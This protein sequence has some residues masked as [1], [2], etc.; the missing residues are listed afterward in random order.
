MTVR[1]PC[2]EHPISLKLDSL[3]MRYN[4][5]RKTKNFLEKKILRE[6]TSNNILDFPPKKSF[7]QKDIFFRKS[8]FLKNM[9][10]DFRFFIRFFLVGFRVIVRTREVFQMVSGVSIDTYLIT[11]KNPNKK[12]YFIMEKKYFLKNIFFEKSK[13]FGENLKMLILNE[14]SK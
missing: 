11:E 6:K 1:S 9:I 12:Q 10:F 13:I 14:N 2:S 3:G 8:T 4:K 5:K 7:F